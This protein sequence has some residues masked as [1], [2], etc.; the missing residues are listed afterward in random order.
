MGKRHGNPDEFL[1]IAASSDPSDASFSIGSPLIFMIL[2][3]SHWV[4]LISIDIY[5]FPIG[6]SLVF[7][8]FVIHERIFLCFRG[9][10]ALS[11]KAQFASSRGNEVVFITRG[12]EIFPSK[13]SGALLRAAAPLNGGKI[14]SGL[15]PTGGSF[16]ANFMNFH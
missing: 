5:W 10:S 8:D 2:L 7:S 11:F 4:L 6:F 3:N 9:T 16:F 12:C 15:W 14:D 13:Q 1:Q